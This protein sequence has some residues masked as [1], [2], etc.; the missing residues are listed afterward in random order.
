[1]QSFITAR[2]E[3]DDL[4]VE[5]VVDWFGAVEV[6]AEYS[7]RACWLRESCASAAQPRARAAQGGMAV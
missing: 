7:S 5:G 2:F 6:V 3:E 1:M 4:P